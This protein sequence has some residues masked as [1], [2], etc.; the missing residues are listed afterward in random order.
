MAN[1]KTPS[2]AGDD[3]LLELQSLKPTVNTKQQD[4][5]WWIRS[6][7]VGGLAAGIYADQRLIANDAFPQRS[8]Q[9]ATQKFLETYFGP[10]PIQGNFLPATQS[11]GLV[12]VTGT[13]GQVVAQGLQAVYTPNGNTYASQETVTLDAIAATGLIQFQSLGA[14][15]DQNLSAFA[16]L[17]IP[18][19]PAGL[20]PAAQVASGGMADARDPETNAQAQARILQRI[21]EPLSVGRVSDYVQY[22]EAADPSVTSAS[23][24]RYPFGLGTVG[25]YITSG[26]TDIDAAIDSGTPISIIP[27]DALVAKVQANLDINSPVTDCVTV[28]KP[29]TKAIDATVKVS[30][31]QGTLETILSGQSLTQRELIQREVRRAIYKT[32]VGGRQIGASGFVLASEMEETIDVKLSAES[33]VQGSIPILLDRQVLPLSATG[34]NIALSPNEAPVEGTITVVLI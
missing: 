7:V 2:Q 1:V 8:R 25:V 26:T 4:S 27:S 15:Q 3:Y 14:G 16:D 28:L 32:P 9:D 29:T 23:V 22:A 18:S 24:S 13:P 19:P 21:R 20:N 34:Y 6:R 12:A 31:S 11:N 33:V 30:L 5:D 17:N 10:D